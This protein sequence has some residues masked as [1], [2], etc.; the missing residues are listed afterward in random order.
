MW[1]LFLQTWNTCSKKIRNLKKIGK[2]SCETTTRQ[3]H[4]SHSIIIVQYSDSYTER[5]PQLMARL[6]WVGGCVLNERDRRPC[7]DVGSL[8]CIHVYEWATKLTISGSHPTT[9]NVKCIDRELY[10][11]IETKSVWVI[12]HKHNLVPE[13]VTTLQNCH[14]QKCTKCLPSTWSWAK[15]GSDQ[16][17]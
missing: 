2:I 17:C 6:L 8:L 13:G 7:V 9:N 12:K 10:R 14:P 15:Y 16:T 1:E 3:P 5:H 4:C 11:N